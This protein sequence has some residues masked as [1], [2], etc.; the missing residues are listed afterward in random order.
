[1]SGPLRWLAGKSASMLRSITEYIDR[2]WLW[3]G[4]A[5][6]PSNQEHICAIHKVLRDVAQG[7]TLHVLHAIGGL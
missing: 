4:M 6:P 7:Q 5:T 1:M 2:I 3:H